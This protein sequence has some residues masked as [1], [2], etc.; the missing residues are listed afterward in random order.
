[1]Q[2]AMAGF[3]EP[4]IYTMPGKRTPPVLCPLGRNPD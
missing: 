2:W 1:M 4:V 3:G